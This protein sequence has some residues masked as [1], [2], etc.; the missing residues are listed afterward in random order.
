MPSTSTIYRHNHPEYAL[1]EKEQTRTRIVNKYNNDPE[2]RELLKK[3]ALAYY[4]KK[5]QAKE[6]KYTNDDDV[7]YY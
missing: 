5:K 4:Y 1:K 3:R 2:Y 7:E 6:I